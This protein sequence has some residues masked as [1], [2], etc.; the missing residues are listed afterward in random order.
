MKK[1]IELANVRDDSSKCCTRI[2][3][4]TRISTLM[5]FQACM[6]MS[7]FLTKEEAYKRVGCDPRAAM[8]VFVK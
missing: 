3:K 8:F 7:P 5:Q 4:L 2:D 1:H 6:P